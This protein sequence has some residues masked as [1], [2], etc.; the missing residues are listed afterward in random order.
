M[1]YSNRQRRRLER[2]LPS[3][4]QDRLVIPGRQLHSGYHAVQHSSGTTPRGDFEMMDQQYPTTS[5]RMDRQPSAPLSY[6]RSA[7]SLQ[8]ASYDAPRNIPLRSGGSSSAGH[9]LDILPCMVLSHGCAC[10]QCV[11]TQEIGFSELCGA[12][13]TIIPPGLHIVWG[14]PFRRVA[15]RLTLRTQQWDIRIETLT[16]DRV[17]VTVDVCC[18]FRVSLHRSFDAFYRLKD[19][20][21]AISTCLVDA[22]QTICPA[23]TLNDLYASKCQMSDFIVDRLGRLLLEFGYELHKVLVTRI[24][25]VAPVK[26]AMDDVAASRSLKFAAAHQAE[27]NKVV[28]VRKAEA[29]AERMSL[30]GHATAR[31]QQVIV[32]HMKQS[33]VLFQE[34][35][36]RLVEPPSLQQVMTILLMAQY[37]DLLSRLKPD[38]VQLEVEPEALCRIEDRLHS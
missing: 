1:S 33:A 22:V 20:R 28:V 24:L 35:D 5:M 7:T 30:M 23:L 2:D 18:M 26:D 27:A 9:R 29:H 16:L 25:P 8:H 17:F 4:L 34:V 12:F 19:P 36:V 3:T 13:E 38:R 10:I 32:D 15:G 6:R 37:M 31:Q 14:W 21:M 11:R